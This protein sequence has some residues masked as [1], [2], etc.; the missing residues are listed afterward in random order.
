MLKAR[1]VLHAHHLLL[2]WRRRASL[3]HLFSA[4]L[5]LVVIASSLIG[6]VLWTLVLMR[7]AIILKAPDYLIDV[8]RGVLVELLIVPEDDNGDVDGTQD[9]QLMRLL[10]QAAFPL[11]EGDGS[12]A[13][14]SDGLDLIEEDTSVDE[15]E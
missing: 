9:G 14:V 11:E 8:G 7:A 10:E 1:M 15:S 13:I 12:V 5:V 6:E 2:I 3:V 4:L